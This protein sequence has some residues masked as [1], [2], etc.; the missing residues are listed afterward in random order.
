MREN[1]FW[2]SF[3]FSKTFALRWAAEKVAKFDLQDILRFLEHH[4][5]TG[6]LHWQEKQVHFK[7]VEVPTI[8]DRDQL[9]SQTFD[10]SIFQQILIFSD[11]ERKQS[12][13]KSQKKMV[14]E[15]DTKIIGGLQLESL[16]EKLDFLSDFH[17]SI[18]SL[19]LPI[20]KGKQ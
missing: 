11:D 17:L 5:F 15:W 2:E 12:L 16:V 6:K 19:W 14:F 4:A 7:R 18:S 3:E 1:F 13:T 10:C 20:I 8:L 9:F